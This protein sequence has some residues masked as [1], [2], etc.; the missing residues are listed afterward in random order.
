MGDGV[1]EK[2]IQGPRFEVI[3]SRSSE[4][5]IVGDALRR[6]TRYTI[7]SGEITFIKS[8]TTLVDQKKIHL[9][10][11]EEARKA[12]FDFRWVLARKTGQCIVQ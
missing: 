1:V 2:D 5:D 12:E 7:R 9:R 3:D 4:Y 11:Y 8:I 6:A 10:R